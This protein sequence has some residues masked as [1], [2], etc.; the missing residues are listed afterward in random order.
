ME[1]ESLQIMESYFDVLY[2]VIISFLDIHVR[3]S[4]GEQ[5]MY[6]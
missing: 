3:G 5:V 2:V 4:I 1:E 6:R